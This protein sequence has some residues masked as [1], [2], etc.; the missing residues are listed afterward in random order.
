MN[1]CIKL[2]YSFLSTLTFSNGHQMAYLNKYFYCSSNHISQLLWCTQSYTYSYWYAKMI[3]CLWQSSSK[4]VSQW[5]CVFALAKSAKNFNNI[6]PKKYRSTTNLDCGW[7][8]TVNLLT[9]I[10]N[11]FPKTLVKH[12]LPTF[13]GGLGEKFEF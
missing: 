3:Y 7:K 4:S 11:L 1:V 2:I 8:K 6:F 9:S 10:S 12:V 5:H 13:H